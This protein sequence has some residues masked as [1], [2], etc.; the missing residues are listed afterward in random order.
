MDTLATIGALKALEDVETYYDRGRYYPTVNVKCHVWADS[1]PWDELEDEFGDDVTVVQEWAEGLCRSG[2]YDQMDAAWEIAREFWWE[3]AEEQAQE[4]FGNR[5]K[6]WSFGRQ[7]GHLVVDGIGAPDEWTDDI[8]AE[9]YPECCYDWDHD[10]TTIPDVRAV[11]QWVE[12]QRIIEATRDDFPYQVG[13]HL[14]VNVH[15]P[16][17]DLQ[18]VI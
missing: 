13:W 17:H 5:A 14:I 1:I 12:F 18:G 9:C 7:G 15:N 2:E 16:I 3:Y 8:C 4:I 11:S 10:A 6:V